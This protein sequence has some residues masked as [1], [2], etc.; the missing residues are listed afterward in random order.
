MIMSWLINSMTKETYSDKGNTSEIFEIKSI[1]HDLRQGEL[2]V[3]EYF[4][5]L[6]QKWQQLDMLEEEMEAP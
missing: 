2:P 6:T 3:N 1:L 5:T 4:N